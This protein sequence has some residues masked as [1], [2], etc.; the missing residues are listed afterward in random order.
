MGRPGQ[1]LYSVNDQVWRDWQGRRMQSF[2][3]ATRAY[4]FSNSAKEVFSVALYKHVT[5][6][7]TRSGFPYYNLISLYRESFTY[8]PSGTRSA[9]MWASDIETHTSTQFYFISFFL[10]R[11]RLSIIF[12]NC[13]ITILL[14]DVFLKTGAKLINVNFSYLK[15][16]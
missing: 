6:S 16:M 2:T 9:H 3:A 4:S 7:G 1:Q 15:L 11:V 13:F 10:P 14:S 8:S 12:N 5:H